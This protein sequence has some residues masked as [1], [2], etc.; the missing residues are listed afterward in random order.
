MDSFLPPTPKTFASLLITLQQRSKSPLAQKKMSLNRYQSDPVI[1][2]R[3]C[4][5]MQ[6]SIS[7]AGRDR[8]TASGKRQHNCCILSVSVL[9]FAL[10]DHSH[11]LSHWHLKKSF[12]P[13]SS[14][15]HPAQ[16][17]SPQRS[18]ST[19]ASEGLWNH[20]SLPGPV[21]RSTQ[22]PRTHSP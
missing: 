11:D 19:A 5:S 17:P 18:F 15:L 21:D 9:R 7:H 16:S 13:P 14:P 20:A 2:F 22:Y 1:R 3:P 8:G 10:R 6:A 4:A 12:T